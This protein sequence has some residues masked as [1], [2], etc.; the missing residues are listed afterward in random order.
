MKTLILAAAAAF[1]LSLSPAD[2][3]EKLKVHGNMNVNLYADYGVGVDADSVE[4]KLLVGENADLADPPYFP[5]F[6]LPNYLS[7]VDR[8]LEALEQ[9]MDEFPGPLS[10]AER[11]QITA[12]AV[13]RIAVNRAIMAIGEIDGNVT[14]DIN[15]ENGQSDVSVSVEVL[16][17]RYTRATVAFGVMTQWLN[18]SGYAGDIETKITTIEG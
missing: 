15:T 10:Q 2:A 13:A 8:H 12:A 7:D 5:G 17:G 11:Q 6:L 14:I 4:K 18:A 3:S 1:A 9:A 16:S